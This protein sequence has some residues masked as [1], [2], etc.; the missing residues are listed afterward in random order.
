MKIAQS[1]T[2][3]QQQ[4]LLAFI[5]FCGCSRTP[6]NLA[7]KIADAD[8]VVAEFAAG[9][10]AVSNSF[11]G[12]EARQLVKVVSRAKLDSHQDQELNAAAGC[13]LLFYK[14]TNLLARVGIYKKYLWSEEGRFVETSGAVEEAYDEVLSKFRP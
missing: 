7:H 9:S 1:L 6:A 5:A 3:R 2:L 12:K 14:G 4:L 8:R 10:S 11:S 13:S